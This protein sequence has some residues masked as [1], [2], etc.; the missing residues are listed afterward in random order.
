M[1][2]SSGLGGIIEQFP[3]KEAYDDL[4]HP[5]AAAV[6]QTISLPFRAVNVLLSPLQKW[7]LQG[8]GR[9]EEMSRLVSE[10]LKNVPQEKLTEPDPYVA[11]PAMQAFS[12]SMDCDEL[13]RMYAKLLAKAIHVDEKNSVHPS[14]VE[15]I[16]QMS[17][18]DAKMLKFICKKQGSIAMCN[19]RWQKKSPQ[20]WQVLPNFRCPTLGHDCYSH[21]FF[22]SE[23]DCSPEE[24][25]VSF[26]NLARLSL[27][28]IE[29]DAYL[30]PKHYQGLNGIDFASSLKEK[31]SSLPKCD[32]RELALVP[33]F[34]KM[35]AFG[36]SFANICLSNTSEDLD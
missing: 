9:I 13:K 21:F 28:E 19:V 23:D 11:V 31:I 7:V 12:Y 17:P 32:E 29:D 26:E 20:M 24:I 35:T 27:I 22:V 4:L 6:G 10:E 15:I 34:C 8:E 14:Y 16:K 2:E 25:T 33:G 18:L 36:K 1:G 3:I 30:E 5:A